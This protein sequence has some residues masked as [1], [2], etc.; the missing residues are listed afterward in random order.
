MTEGKP[1]SPPWILSALGLQARLVFAAVLGP[2]FLISAASKIGGSD[3]SMGPDVAGTFLSLGAF[4]SLAPGQLDAAGGDAA[5]LPIAV[6]IAVHTLVLAEALLPVLLVIGFATRL[7]AIGLIGLVITTSAIDIFGHGAPPEVVG[8]LFDANPYSQILDQRLLWIMLLS[9][10][11]A[12]GGGW[13]SIDSALGTL[14]R[15]HAR[16]P[17]G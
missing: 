3:L 7:A 9:V 14:R 12:L 16:R 17:A 13:L 6:L 11:A 4:Y 15:R 1:I 2:F 8:G 10:P 5:M